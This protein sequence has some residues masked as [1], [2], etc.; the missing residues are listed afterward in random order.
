MTPHIAEIQKAVAQR[1][2][3]RIAEMTSD[4][5]SRCVAR[6]RQVA[7]YLAKELTPHSL[8]AIGKHFGDRDHKTVMH[9]I[10]TVENLISRDQMF[11]AAV[12]QVV[13]ALTDDPNQET[14]PL[15]R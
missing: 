14:L 5:R 12:A 8:P 7:M 4:R 1:W 6:P 9:A 15:Y 13:R 2:G 11:A 3:I 10:K